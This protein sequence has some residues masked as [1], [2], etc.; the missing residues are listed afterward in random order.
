MPLFR[1]KSP[2]PVVFRHLRDDPVGR[3]W[4]FFSLR[5]KTI[6]PL[7]VL[8]LVAS[9]GAAYLIIDAVARQ[10]HD[11]EI[12][13]L[14][15][16]SRA[17]ADRMMTLT[18][19][20]GREVT[21]IAYTQ[22]VAEGVIAGDGMALHPILEPLAAAADLD[23]LLVTDPA[24]REIL[25]LQRSVTA[26]G[27]VDYAVATGTDLSAW[28]QPG[29]A[30]GDGAAT[31][32]GTTS[33]AISRSLIARTGQGHA[34]LTAG[35]VLSGGEL[36]GM[37]LAGQ[38][39]EHMIEA[40]RGGDAVEIA[41]FGADGEFLRTTLPFDDSTRAAIQV[42][43]ETFAQALSTPGQVPIT[44]LD[45]GGDTYHAAYLPLVVNGSPL[46]VVVLYQ[47]DDTLY[48]TTRSREVISLMAAA[49]VGMV[50]VVT[51]VVMGRFTG[52]LERVT[53][54]A[55][56]LAAGDARA[57][58]GMAGTDEVGELGATLDRLADRQQRR[59]DALQESLRRQRA[60]TAHL[61][62]VVESIPDGIVVQDL[63][64]RVLMINGAA[65][66]LLGGQRTFRAARLHELTAVVTETLGPAL[67]PGIYALGD[68]T[69]VPLDERMLQAQAAA[70]LTR[71]KQRIGTVIVLRDITADV[72][73]EQARERL[74]DQ[75]A[76]Q[77]RAPGPYESLS[78]LAREVTR[79][80]RAIQR[81]IADLRDLSTFEPRDLQAGQCALPL[82]ELLWNIAAEWQPLAR[83]AK[84]RLD[85]RFG[86]RGRHILGDDR[87]LRWAIGNLVDNALKY[88][89]P[90]TVITLSTRLSPGDSGAA[91]VVVQDQGY[92][93]APDDLT[94]AFTRFY[95]GTPHDR[96]GRPVRQPGTGQGLYIARR[97][98]QAH[99]GDIALAS[100][101]GTGTA[102]SGTTAVVTLP[103]TAPVT[104]EMPDADIPVD[105]PIPA[106]EDT[107]GVELSE[108][109][110]YDTVPLDKRAPFWDE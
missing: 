79:N 51:F 54:T 62:A 39:L 24:G 56:A 68:P 69:R 36:V 44:S 18:A 50:T 13:R 29:P 64:G 1:R 43:P 48:A 5:W 47:L 85:V 60:D 34:L 37:V 92:G 66:E 9:M 52:R 97:V 67:A 88:S 15:R 27:A 74:I 21:R 40:L 72:E 8:V 11:S 45:I 103:L 4:Y 42:G 31:G 78:E 61:A 2:E 83:I 33:P 38:R 89:P 109:A 55:N 28:V 14:L 110:G 70:I 86:P 7:M 108:D 107:T 63:D 105:E 35:P 102:A 59:V 49:L 94:N 99:G 53:R 77:A 71:S 20:Q 57:R 98:I 106:P 17:T 41:V 16:T 58:T 19:D 12:D 32:G 96:D 90:G 81:V 80:T 75:L 3:P 104:L 30:A 95:R 46:G 82:N 65:R 10:S 26:K 91:Q 101:I 93:I 22:G 100:R 84:I 87:R 25:G 23:Y 6:L 76:D 73:R